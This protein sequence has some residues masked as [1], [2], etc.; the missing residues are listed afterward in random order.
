MK[1]QEHI[2]VVSQYFYPEQF[3]INDICKEW[4][5]AGHKVTVLTG[6]P[7][8]PQGKFY[9]GY[10]LF[11]NNSERWEDMD[12]IRLPIIPRGSNPV[13]LSLNYLSFVISGFFWQ[14]CTQIKPDKVF[15]YEVSPMTQALVGVWLANRRK[16]PCYMYVTDLWPENFEY[17]TGIHSKL[18]V[19]PIEWMVKYLYKSCKKIFISSRSFVNSIKSKGI[20]E[21]KIVYWPQ[22]AEDFYV[23]KKISEIDKNSIRIRQDG[24]FHI[25]FAGNIGEAQGLDVLVD[26]AKILKDNGRNNVLFCIVGDGRHKA[27][28]ME[29]VE[30][31]Q[32][33]EMF[34][35]YPRIPAVQIPDVF[36]QT[37]AA[38]I[39][40]SKS[41]VFALTLP[42]KTQSCLACGKPVIV[43]ADGE[44]QNIIEEAMCGVAANANDAEALAEKIEDM[45]SWGEVELAQMSENAISYYSKNFD[46][47]KLLSDMDKYMDLSREKA[48]NFVLEN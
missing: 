44:I 9:K 2:L 47:K 4:V 18:I 45:L 17:I 33:S 28:L 36:A 37:D 42:A 22:Y 31:Q 26:T 10:G 23:H 6:V 3:R 7:N 46:K 15:V 19:T 16:I 27:T 43:S 29:N 40:L 24:R 11:K 5:S 8:Y 21:E 20:K 1:K 14:I 32:V 30:R 35:F 41:D 25:L 48:R 13:M 38:L 12:I 34:S 39:C